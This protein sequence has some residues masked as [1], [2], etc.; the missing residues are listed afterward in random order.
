LTLNRKLGSK[1]EK[2]K[3]SSIIIASKSNNNSSTNNRS[4]WYSR[5]VTSDQNDQRPYTFKIQNVPKAKIENRPEGFHTKIQSYIK[6]RLH[7][8]INRLVCHTT[9]ED[10]GTIPRLMQK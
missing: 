5:Q 1:N 4:H 8:Q 6:D 9:T 3:S 10:F 2:E 7:H